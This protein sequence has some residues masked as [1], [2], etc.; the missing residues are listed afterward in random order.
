MTTAMRGNPNLGAP[1]PRAEHMVSPVKTHS[2]HS[3]GLESKKL[4]NRGENLFLDFSLYR[5][6]QKWGTLLTFLLG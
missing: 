2:A 6:G 5:T 3:A 1:A 4:S